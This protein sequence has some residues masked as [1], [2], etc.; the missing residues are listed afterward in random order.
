ML[1]QRD[2]PASL[3][4]WLSAGGPRPNVVTMRLLLAISSLLMACAT[5]PGVDLPAGVKIV[6]H[7]AGYSISYIDAV[8]KPR[9][10]LTPGELV[11][12][13]VTVGYR[14]ERAERGQVVLVLQNDRGRLLTLGRKQVSLPV[15][16]GTGQVTLSDTITIPQGV[17]A[18]QLFVPLVPEGMSVSRGE[19]AVTYPV[20]GGP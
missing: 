19:L 7:D 6:G 11:A 2:R 5:S 3:S 17:R 1:I 15:E 13:S 14:L 4:W 20:R 9:S 8:P 12:F 10:T 18:I 16:R